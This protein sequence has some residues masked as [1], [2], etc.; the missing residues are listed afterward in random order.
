MEEFEIPPPD[1]NPFEPI[2][3][4]TYKEEVNDN[5]VNCVFAPAVPDFVL[6]ELGQED[7]EDKRNECIAKGQSFIQIT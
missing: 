3:V 7:T 2:N 4:F 1:V 5:K 6:I